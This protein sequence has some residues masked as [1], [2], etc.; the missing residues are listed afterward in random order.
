VTRLAAKSILAIFGTAVFSCVAAAAQDLAREAGDILSRRCLGCHGPK[1]KA[2]GLD[3]SSR[4]SALRGGAKG[5]AFSEKFA[6]DSLIL[7]RVLS[8]T[9]PPSA[10]LGA[11]EREILKRWIE[12]GAAWSDAVGERRGGPDWWSLQP[13]R[14]VSSPL[15][16]A[17]GETPIDRFVT[18]KLKQ[19]GLQ[20]SAKANRREL[21]RRATFDFTGLPPTPEEVGAFVADHSPDAYEKLVDRLL[22][23][24][25]YGERWGRH[26][27]DVA[28]F[29]ES[30]GFERDLVREH[31]WRYRDY[32]IRSFNNDKPFIDFA[33]EQIA[34]DVLDNATHDSIIATGFLVSGPTDAVG[35]TSAVPRE[36]QAVREDQ[37]EEMVSAVSQSFLG[38]TTNCARCHDHK[39]D[40][41]PQR[42]YYAFKAA[43]A[44]VWQPVQ[45][46]SSIELLPDGRPLLT[47]AEQS[48]A[49]A[50]ARVLRDRIET[51][52]S[53]LS[54]LYRAVRDRLLKARG[55]QWPANVP[56]PISQWTFDT[57]GRDPV[58]GVHLLDFAGRAKIAD[59]R[60]LPVEKE[61]V[62]L[63]TRQLSRNVKEKTLEAWILVGKA[64]ELGTSVLFIQNQSGYRGASQDGIQYTGAKKNKQWENESTARFRSAEVNGPQESSKGGDRL[65]I[66]ITYGADGTV[67]IYR[68]GTPYGSAYRPEVDGPSGQLQTY[69]ANDAVVQL[70]TSKALELDEARMYDFALSEQQIADS[71]AGGAPSVTLA[72]SLTAMSPEDRARAG[73]LE[74]ELVALRAKREAVAKPEKSFAAVVLEPGPTH[75]LHRGDIGSPKEVVAPA[76]LS[77]VKGVSPNFGISADASD[78]ER[79]RKMAEWIANPANPLFSRVIV[80]RVWHY[81]FGAGIVDSPND[82]GY[83]GGQPSHPE[84]LDFLAA[85]FIQNGWSLKK[86]HKAIMMSET[87]QQSSRFDPQA[88]AKD[89]DNRLLWRFTP[90]R[91]EGETIRDAMLHVSGALNPKMDGPSFRPFNATTPGG[92]Y[93]KYEP[94]DSDD[95]AMQRR[96]VYRMNVSTGG[97]PMLE[98][99]DCPVPSVKTP[100]RAITTT[101][102]Q[103]LSLMNG[104]FAS[105]MAKTFAARVRNEAGANV[106]AQVDRAFRL[107][108]ARRPTEQELASSRALVEQQQLETL[109]WGLFNATEFLQ[110]E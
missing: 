47:P 20:L 23:S 110:V 87:Y 28:R 30:E 92:S 1:T 66:A 102:L 94:K 108:L 100:K 14:S 67:R 48:H 57:D 61:G 51:V 50:E 33:R 56:R 36:R 7:Q 60:I 2:S 63:L 53:Q 85:D 6:G 95:P 65:H 5:P 29:S 43:F 59:G 19:N 93:V 96:T 104:A 3:L 82:F 101:P 44:G 91:L 38:L 41:I 99:L 46:R 86:L 45:D 80:N 26:W 21:I 83:N 106:D 70:T 73:E 75:L 58:G 16:D 81:H 9:M 39:F 37:L 69:L 40:P 109:C 97:E 62:R 34:G 4:A 24:P 52:E 25:H 68:N 71:Y 32:V 12:A 8:G 77:A 90:R 64:P 89:A 84:L 88:A 15:A 72:E 22:A 107:A 98:A 105:R 42:D 17:S 103:A 31:S 76:G 55:Y 11:T 13:L 54:G 27:L 10:P 18:A 79:R 35:L 78:R 49:D 74:K